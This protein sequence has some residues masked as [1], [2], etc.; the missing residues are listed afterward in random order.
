ML[1]TAWGSV[2]HRCA[3]CHILQPWFCCSW[4]C[5][6]REVSA[7]YSFTHCGL[8]NGTRSGGRKQVRQMGKPHRGAVAIG[9]E[10]R[11]CQIRFIQ[12]SSLPCWLTCWMPSMPPAATTHSLHALLCQFTRKFCV[13]HSIFKRQT[14]PKLYAHSG[15][16]VSGIV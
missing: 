3:V 9:W 13:H 14:I 7:A 2:H 6:L 11:N 1:H 10:R 5:H 12:R 4:V 8:I 16:S 15:G